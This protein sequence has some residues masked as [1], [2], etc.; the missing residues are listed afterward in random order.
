MQGRSVL[1]DS[2]EWQSV[3]AA[4]ASTE[5]LLAWQ[6]DIGEMGTF[7]IFLGFGS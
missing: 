6:A 1:W 5:N 4:A 7:L 2:A 3:E